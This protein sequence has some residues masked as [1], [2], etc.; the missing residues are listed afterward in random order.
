MPNWFNQINFTKLLDRTR[1]K[2]RWMF[3]VRADVW[4]P[5]S[6]NQEEE[7]KT[8]ESVLRTRLKKITGDSSVDTLV[9]ADITFEVPSSGVKG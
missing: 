1:K 2:N 5:P 7:Q 8:A 6:E 9:D 4:M 3:H